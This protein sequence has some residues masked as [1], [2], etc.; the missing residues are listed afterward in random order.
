MD[1]LMGLPAGLLSM[2]LA[3]LQE[4]VVYSKS[5]LTAETLETLLSA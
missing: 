5:R 1:L 4:L 3:F 2:H